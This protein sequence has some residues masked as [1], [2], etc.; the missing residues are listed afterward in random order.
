MRKRKYRQIVTC[1]LTAAL[2][3]FAGQVQSVLA[4][5]EA[6]S[7]T[8]QQEV[9]EDET[10]ALL[11]AYQPNYVD[12]AVKNVQ[13]QINCLPTADE[14]LG[15]EQEAQ[16]K[17]YNQ[18]QTAYDAY[19]ALNEEQKAQIKGAEIFDN[20]FEVFNGMTNALDAVGNFNVEGDSSTYSYAN[21]VLTVNDGANLTIST[22]GQISDRIVIASGAKANITLAGVNITPANAGTNDGY[23][24]I[25]LGSG[26]TLNI[27][28][29]D[30]STNEICGGTSITGS[31][32]PG[33]RVPEYST[34]TIGGDGSLVVNGVSGD[35]ASVGIGGKKTAG[36]N[37][38]NCGNVI[39]LGGIITVHGGTASISNPAVD[40]GGGASDYG[41][42]GACNTVIILTPVNSG[43]SLEIGGGACAGAGSIAGSDGQG[44]RPSGDGSYTVWGELT[45]PSGIEF[46]SDITLNIPSGTTLN[47]PKD[48][49]WPENIKVMGDGT[50]TPDTKKL[51]AMITLDDDLILAT[52]NPINLNYTYNGD[53]QVTITWYEDENKTQKLQEAPKG[54]CSYWI[55]MSA[56]ATNLYQALLETKKIKVLKGLRA[57]TIPVI[58]QTKA[59]SITVDTVPGHKYICTT[60]EIDYMPDPNEPGWIDATGET[61]TFEGL[62][63][64]KLYYITAYWPGN[65]YFVQSSAV[66][67][68]TTTG[69]ADYTVTIPAKPMTAGDESTVSIAVDPDT[70]DIG[71]GGKV[72]VSA[73]AEV[74]LTGQE[75]YNKDVT[76]TS[77]LLVDG[78]EHQGNE[79]ISFDQDNYK[80]QSAKIRFAKPVRSDGGIIP[81]GNYAGKII[82]T[83]S[84]SENT[85]S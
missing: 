25:E 4:K 6:S 85:A 61:Y 77:S 78:K 43:G 19:E 33:I 46:P 73:P 35:E 41:N 2:V 48:F 82:F 72:T 67:A 7:E 40:I 79:I 75:E 47:L 14:L 50:I 45:L 57:A 22:N 18:L 21:G 39:V 74:T 60:T 66:N 26:A 76:L 13:A 68:T 1:L 11:Q 71:Y 23:S 17:V 83:V 63:S 36:G 58:K 44:I 53:G 80:T 5:T 20:L 8:V 42:G 70:F 3:L 29:Q 69:T 65:E 62:H 54:N 24:G 10:S 28:L 12:E 56:E 31:P 81:A 55:E 16:Q 38:E 9:S 27:T 15:M 30:A 49:T 64:N 51:P 59:G 37:G 52:G 32:G 34:L 84:Y